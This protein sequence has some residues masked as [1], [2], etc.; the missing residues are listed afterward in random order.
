MAINDDYP[1]K[2][3]TENDKELQTEQTYNSAPTSTTFTLSA[4]N[5]ICLPSIAVNDIDWERHPS[6]RYYYPRQRISHE[7]RRERNEKLREEK[8][9]EKIEHS[10]EELSNTVTTL[11][12][13]PHS[14]LAMKISSITNASRAGLDLAGIVTKFTLETMKLST[15]TSLSIAKAVTGVVSDAMIQATRD[16]IG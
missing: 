15:K 10:E 14:D 11:I 9:G 12:H 2:D 8:V 4:S 3:S 6:D 5:G 16:G 1:R 13:Q 7:R